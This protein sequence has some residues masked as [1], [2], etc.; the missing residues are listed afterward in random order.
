MG[1]GAT[2]KSCKYFTSCSEKTLKMVKKDSGNGILLGS[3]IDPV[4]NPDG[5]GFL[6]PAAK[7]GRRI[8]IPLA[9]RGTCFCDASEYYVGKPEFS[10][11]TKEARDA[12]DYFYEHMV[13]EESQAACPAYKKGLFRKD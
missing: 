3:L 12:G 8:L 13:I 4:A 7:L 5:S 2:C 6:Q 1:D 11:K 9:P 10:A